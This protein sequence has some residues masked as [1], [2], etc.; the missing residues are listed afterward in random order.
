VRKTSHGLV[1]ILVLS[2]TTLLCPV[3]HNGRTSIH[4][5]CCECLNFH[6]NNNLMWMCVF[7]KK[8][9]T[10]VVCMVLYMCR[11]WGTPQSLLLRVS[12]TGNTTIPTTTC[13]G[14]R[15]HHNPYH[16]VCR[17]QGTPQS[18]PLR[19]SGTGNTTIP[20]TTCVVILC[21]SISDLSW[22]AYSLQKLQILNS[23]KLKCTQYL[24]AW[25]TLQELKK[26][27]CI[28]N[29]PEMKADHSIQEQ[30]VDYYKQKVQKTSN[31]IVPW[32]EDHTNNQHATE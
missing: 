27:K 31:N 29:A 17:G 26:H 1:N 14:N 11:G 3:T 9:P 19:V 7:R 18:L 24:K 4:S 2:C 5:I 8:M 15:E 22:M 25:I 20:T 32:K 21:T 6:H 23:T 12:G 10:T 13:V 28:P 16:C 30:E